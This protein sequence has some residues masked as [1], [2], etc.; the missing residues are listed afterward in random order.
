[1]SMVIH[2]E[3][4]PWRPDLCPADQ[5]FIDLV[6]SEHISGRRI[7]HMGTGMHHNVGKALGKRNYVLGV[8]CSP[9]E[10]QAYT[11]LI[12]EDPGLQWSYHCMFADIH[13][14]N[15]NEFRNFDIIT[16]FHL[17]ELQSDERAK[18]LVYHEDGVIRQAWDH[19]N[20]DGRIIMYKGSLA[21]DRIMPI[22]FAV[23]GGPSVEYRSLA[24][25]K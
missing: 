13:S 10:M 8:T 11:D 16:L 15:L 24:I 5:D 22:A 12:I 18:Y 3:G 4:W 1:M 17:G 20:N 25:W 9:E 14:F 21:A 7:L 6:E 19:L 23:L 2:E